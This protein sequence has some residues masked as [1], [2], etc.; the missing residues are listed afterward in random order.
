MTRM[1]RASQA[2]DTKVADPD[3]AY[4]VIRAERDAICDTCTNFVDI[5]GGDEDRGHL[6]RFDQLEAVLVGI[7][8][9]G[10]PSL[11]P[12][13]RQTVRAAIRDMA[14]M[15]IKDGLPYAWQQLMTAIDGQYAHPLTKLAAQMGGDVPPVCRFR[16]EL[17]P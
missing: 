5:F 7:V 1:V 16:K 9:K 12:K 13:H 2:A 8:N 15:T 6:P 14:N 11:Q 17:R 4:R 3:L 10:T